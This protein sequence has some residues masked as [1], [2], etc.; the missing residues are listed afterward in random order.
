MRCAALSVAAVLAVTGCG[1]ND[2]YQQRPRPPA[3]KRVAP[4]DAP[5]PRPSRPQ[6]PHHLALGPQ[7]N[8]R[9]AVRAFARRWM[10]WNWRDVNR[11]QREL[12]TL[13]TGSYAEQLLADA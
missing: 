12:A 7:P 1:V 6:R 9:A 2:P 10:N 5:T 8:A 13:A 3:A 11:Q 4:T